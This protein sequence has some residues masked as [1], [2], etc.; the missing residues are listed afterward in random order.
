MNARSGIL[1]LLA[2]ALLGWFAYWFLTNFERVTEEREVGLR[3]EA[4]ANP[5]LAA[6]RFLAATGVEVRSVEGLGQTPPPNGV[7]IIPTPRY[8][9]GA[10][11]ARDLLGWVRQGG[12]LVVTASRRWDA[13]DE[14]EITDDPLLDPLGLTGTIVDD[15]GGLYQPTDVDWPEAADFLQVEFSA[16]W[17]L[18]STG[19]EPERILE[20]EVGPYLMQFSVGRGRVTVLSDATFMENGNIGRFDHAAFLWQLVQVGGHGPVWLVY[21]DTMPSLPRWLLTHAWQ[22]V[23]SASLLLLL[24]LW[25]ASRRL[26][27]LLPPP[28]PVR[29]RLLEHIEAAG[30]Y[31][32][33]H[34]HAEGLLRGVRASLYRALELRHPAWAQLPSQELYRRLAELS[35]LPPETVQSALL[36]SHSGSEHEFT[37]AIST[38]EHMRKSL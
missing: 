15:Q 1:S 35:G 8:E 37:Q 23:I 3:G 12:H 36:Y 28:P 13:N 5:L 33:R 30:R 26:G 34:G 21:K 16:D 6:R 31:L 18:Q 25:A 32:W 2:V 10:N 38:L 19:P 17:R 24:W 22:V 29:R 4:R 14:S 27:P 9:M 11:Q 7:L 20:D